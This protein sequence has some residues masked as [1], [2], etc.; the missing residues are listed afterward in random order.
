MTRPPLRRNRS[1]PIRQPAAIFQTDVT[2]GWLVTSIRAVRS[3]DITIANME[4]AGWPEQGVRVEDD[5]G[6]GRLNANLSTIPSAPK[7]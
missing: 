7:W 1:E 4:I 6:E 2:S 3:V 5:L